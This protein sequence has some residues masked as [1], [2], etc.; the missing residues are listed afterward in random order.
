M[1]ELKNIT[2]SY[3][4]LDEN[5]ITDSEV[6]KLL[7]EAEEASKNAHAP[8]SGFQVGC[9]L[10]L[11]NG[12][13]L[14]GSN[15]ENVA[16]PSGL[17]AERTVLFYY[18]AHFASVPIKAMAI[19]ADSGKSSSLIPPCGSCRQVMLEYA[20]IQEKPFGIYFPSESKGKWIFIEN[21]KNLLPFPFE[22]FHSKK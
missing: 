10:L 3:L 14:S 9:A 22:R 18:G 21:V 2:F 16:Y 7:K 20:G 4:L 11:E 1:S 6:R 13:I 5:E 17:C 8:Y 15:Q 19:W 12:K